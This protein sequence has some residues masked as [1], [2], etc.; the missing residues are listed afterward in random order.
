LYRVGCFCYIFGIYN[1]AFLRG[2]IAESWLN[3]VWDIIILT[4]DVDNQ[5]LDKLWRALYFWN[6][7]F[8]MWSSWEINPRFWINKDGKFHTLFNSVNLYQFKKLTLLSAISMFPKL[9]TIRIYRL[10]INYM[11]YLKSQDI[12]TSS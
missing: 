7:R 1:P 11:K 9:L 8:A 3:W 6:L 2:V 12:I 10:Q 4:E 5:I